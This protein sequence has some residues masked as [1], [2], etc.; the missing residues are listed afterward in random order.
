MPDAEILKVLADLGGTIALFAIAIILTYRVINR[1][2]TETLR[3]GS[4]IGTEALKIGTTFVET[5]QQ[6]ADSMRMQAQSMGEM[7]DSIASITTR[8]NSEHREILLS[9]QVVGRELRTLRE[10][11]KGEQD[12]PERRAS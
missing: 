3:L 2:G 8:D 9:L 6:M 1:I 11:I 7:K 10:T 5:Q 4:S 12:E